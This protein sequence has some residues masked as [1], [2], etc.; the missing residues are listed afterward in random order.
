MDSDTPAFALHLFLSLSLRVSLLLFDLS[1]SFYLSEANV[2]GPHLISLNVRLKERERE[3]DYWFYILYKILH[4]QY[5]TLDRK[6][7]V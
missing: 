6:S 7:V 3:R 2:S 1:I 5:L 4:R